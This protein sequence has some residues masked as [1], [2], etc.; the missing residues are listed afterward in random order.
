MNADAIFSKSHNTGSTEVSAHR[1]VDAS[2]LAVQLK[3]VKKTYPGSIQAAVKGVNLEVGQG[4]VFTLLGP[5]GSGKTTILRIIAGLENPD[6]GEVCL[7]GRSV[8]LGDRRINIPPHQRDL[9]MVFQS[10]A[11]WPHLTVEQNI[12]FPLKGRG[13]PKSEINDRV[14]HFIELVGLS[15][16][17]KRPGPLLSGGQQQRVALARA[18]VTEPKL[19]LLDEPFNSLDAKLREQMRVELKQL[20]ERLNLAVILVTHDQSESLALSHRMGVLNEGVLL[21]NGKPRELYEKPASE[22]VRDFLGQSILLRGHLR[23][24]KPADIVSVAIDGSSGC[25][26][27]GH[28][29]EPEK[30]DGCRKVCVAV[31][32]EDI[33]IVPSGQ[34]RTCN[35]VTI[36]GLVLSSMFT[37]DRIDYRVNVESQ[38]TFIV[39]GSRHTEVPE[40]NTLCLRLREKGHSVWRLD[41]QGHVQAAPQG[42]APVR[43][44]R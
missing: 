34:S 16:L 30:L 21:Q 4:E 24:D 22:F 8:F 2:A 39:S 3:A 32:P 31:R 13:L 20:Q 10:Y 37:G 14:E 29:C 5:S 9:G 6:S 40:G 1:A 7:S 43:S 26:V 28:V 36:N 18:L 25:V 27:S 15:G 11:I 19:L 41:T 35:G 12:G 17:A 23:N 38:G 33:E 42:P 44:S